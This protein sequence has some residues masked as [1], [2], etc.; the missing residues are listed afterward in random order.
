VEIAEHIGALRD[1]GTLLA[2]A[3]GRIRPASWTD[4]LKRRSCRAARRI[5]T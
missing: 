4:R 2:E 1:H 3:A 5:L